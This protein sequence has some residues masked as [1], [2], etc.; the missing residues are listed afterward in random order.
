MSN[1]A[2]FRVLASA[3]IVARAEDSHSE[4]TA[5]DLSKVVL[6]ELSLPAE[7]SRQGTHPLRDC[8]PE[9]LILALRIGGDDARGVESQYAGV[10]EYFLKNALEVRPIKSVPQ[11]ST[12]GEPRSPEASRPANQAVREIRPAERAGTELTPHEVRLLRLLVEGHRYKT[13]ASALGVSSHTVSFHLR[14]LY[15]KLD[16]HSKS[17]AVSKALRERLV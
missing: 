1:S 12:V 9:V 3:P 17:E 13:A 15:R 14:S 6:L 5:L 11:V 16:V 7:S 10:S 8:F 2:R 4:P